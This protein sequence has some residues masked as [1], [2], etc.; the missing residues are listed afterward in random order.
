MKRT[1]IDSLTLSNSAPPDSVS[2]GA[3]KAM[4]IGVI[5]YSL[6]RFGEIYLRGALKLNIK[7]DSLRDVRLSSEYLAY[8]LRLLVQYC[9]LD[10][11]LEV[12]IS[13]DREY[14]RL[15]ADYASSLPSEE[16]IAKIFAA[17]NQAGFTVSRIRGCVLELLAPV[18]ISAV[19]NLYATVSAEYFC[20][21]YRTFFGSEAPSGSNL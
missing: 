17:A 14:Y 12:N 9:D 13:S 15:C 6:S 4:P 21:L 3:R 19:I 20:T 16:E 1:K 18:E 8:T 11:V 2:L 5:N 7:N 10:R